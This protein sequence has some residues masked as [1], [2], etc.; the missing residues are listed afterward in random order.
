MAS[1]PRPRPIS[2]GD[3]LSELQAQASSLLTDR[4]APA[5]SGAASS[6]AAP[7]RQAMDYLPQIAEY[8]ML[9][10]QFVQSFRERR[11]PATDVAPAR[12]PKPGWAARARPYVIAAGVLGIGY[13]AYRAQRR[14]RPAGRR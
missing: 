5:L 12:N 4:V 1:D 13:A 6:A 10:G 14:S 9:L 3:R 8:A 11:K 7:V 2:H